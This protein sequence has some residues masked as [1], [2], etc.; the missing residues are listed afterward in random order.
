MKSLY[1][2]PVPVI[3]INWNGLEDTR[4]CMSSVL[5]L[6]EVE[7]EIYLI[8]NNSDDNQGQKL[9]AEYGGLPNVH[10][11]LNDENLGFTR[12]SNKVL[13]EII[14]TKRYK[15]VVL[16][17]NDTVVDPEW[18]QNLCRSSIVN[19]ADMVSSKMINYYDRSIMDNAGHFML[20]TAEILPIGHGRP[21]ED[22]TEPF[23]NLGACGGAALYSI[24]MIEDIG[25]FDEY[26]DTGY[27]DAEYG[28]RANKLGYK[29]LFEP[30]AKV[31][32]KVSRSIKK[33][34]DKYYF[35]KIQKNIFYTYIKLM[36]RK[37]IILN[38]AFIVIKYFFLFLGAILSFNFTAISTHLETILSFF[39]ND[40]A[41]ALRSRKEL[42]NNFGSKYSRTFSREIK[43][44]LRTDLRRFMLLFRRENAL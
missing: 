5:S 10:I 25:L 27:E 41:K 26:F 16:L 21:R 15:H 8:D 40:F 2:S 1:S 13:K 3:I 44:F 17:N 36:P 37:F 29:T 14:A 20:N 19:K 28:L 32:H 43:F 38:V 4:E 9:L 18:L 6:K 42:K 12:G 34:R 22:Y 24:R 30:S 11:R 33:I 39:K 31:Y 23:Y 35:M 7:Y